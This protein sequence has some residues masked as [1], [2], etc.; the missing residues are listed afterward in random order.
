MVEHPPFYWEF[1]EKGFEQAVRMGDWKAVRH[2]TKMP[3]ELYDLKW[4][5]LKRRCGE[6]ASGRSERF[7]D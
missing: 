4:T 6:G 5:W 3:I 1:H 2:G 7:E